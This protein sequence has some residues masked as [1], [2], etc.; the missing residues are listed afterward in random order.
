MTDVELVVLDDAEAAA[1][2]A[3]REVAEAAARGGHL[4]LSG[5]ST[6]PV[7]AAAAKLQADWSRVTL[8]F[9]DDRCVPPDDARSNYRLVGESLL[10][11][12]A[13]LPRAVQRVRCERPVEEA[14]A[15]YD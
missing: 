4:A 12:L 2:R 5:G 7:Y 15:L 9:A 8:W 6:R 1:R 14:A 3:A 11:G 13:A 10:D